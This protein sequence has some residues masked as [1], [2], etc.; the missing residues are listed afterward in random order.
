MD[1]WDPLDQPADG[2]Q[3][4]Q[5]APGLGLVRVDP[6]GGEEQEVLVLVEVN[7]LEPAA[8]AQAR[9]AAVRLDTRA[10]EVSPRVWAGSAPVGAG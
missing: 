6:Q 7:Q 10:Y 3:L 8:L 2:H 1:E 4:K 9:E 5:Y